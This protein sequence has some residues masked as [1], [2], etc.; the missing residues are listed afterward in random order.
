MF[1]AFSCSKTEPKNTVLVGNVFGTMFNITYVDSNQ[2]N[3]EKQVDSLFYLV[4]KSLSTYLVNSDI[5]RI[6]EGDENIEVDI[7]FEEVFHKAD[8]IFKETDGVFDPTIGVLVNAWG[9]GPKPG[10]KNLDSIKIKNLL[11]FVGFQKVSLEKRKIHKKYDEIYFDFNAI[12][13]GYGVD[14]IG[15]FL[16]SK[17]I[18]NYLI[19]I[20]GEVRVRGKNIENKLWRIGIEKPNFDGSRSIQKIISLDNECMATSGNYRKYKIDS[21]TGEKYVHTLDTKTGY[22]A[23]RDLLSASVISKLDCADVDGYATSFM[24][25]GFEKT[26]VFLENHPELKVFLIYSDKNGEIMEFSSKNL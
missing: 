19:E 6:N 14:V 2:S 26:L 16:E 20:G 9:F 21:I 18:A 13:K 5:S 3:Y 10:I 25:M 17:G 23:K 11:K 24:A 4:N 22:S 15:R 8:R 7:Y 12:A 1:V